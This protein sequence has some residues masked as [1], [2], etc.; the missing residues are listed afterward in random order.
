MNFPDFGGV[1]KIGKYFF[2]QMLSISCLL[3]VLKFPPKFLGYLTG[4]RCTSAFIFRNKLGKLCGRYLS[5]IRP[6]PYCLLSENTINS[7]S[8]IVGTLYYLG[9]FIQQDEAFNF[10]LEGKNCRSHWLS[11]CLHPL[12]HRDRRLESNL[13]HPNRH[14]RL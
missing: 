14:T 2:F 10:Q 4:N 7:G 1:L 3:Q 12:E 9:C 5:I 6:F 8:F 13:R 11:D